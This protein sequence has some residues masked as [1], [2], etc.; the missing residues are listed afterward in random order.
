M[1]GEPTTVRSNSHHCMAVFTRCSHALWTAIRRI[2]RPQSERPRM[3]R[4]SSRNRSGTRVIPETR[5]HNA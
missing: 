5:G 4:F 1:E 3:S 2:S